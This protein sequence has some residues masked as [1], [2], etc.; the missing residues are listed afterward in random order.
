MAVER[1]AAVA[2]RAAARCSPTGARPRSCSPGATGA[3]G[4]FAGVLL[5]PRYFQAVRDVSATHSG[6]LI[7]PLLLGLVV[8]STSRAR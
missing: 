8:A 1:R 3:F 7:Y 2:D 5:L 6:L 4:L